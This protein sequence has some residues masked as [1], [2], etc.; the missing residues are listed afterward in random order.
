VSFGFSSKLQILPLSKA[1]DVHVLISFTAILLL[2]IIKGINTFITQTAGNTIRL[3][4]KG[5]ISI[6]LSLLRE[7]I[8]HTFNP[9]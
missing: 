7:L 2:L 1:L 4:C 3:Q 8:F 6:K 5:L 9:S